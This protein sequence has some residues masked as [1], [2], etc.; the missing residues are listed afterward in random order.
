MQAVLD[1]PMFGTRWR[2]NA[3]RA[4]ALLRCRGGKKVPPPL[5]RMRAEDLLAAV[6]P[7][8][9]P[10]PRTSPASARSPTIRWCSRRSTTACTRRWTSTASRRLLERDRA[11]RA[12]GSSP[13][14][15]GAVAAA[16]EI[17]NARPYAFLDDAPL[18][19]RRTQAVAAAPLARSR[20]RGG[21][22]RAR[23]RGDR[24]RCARRPGPRRRRR[25][26]ARRA[27]LA[28]L[29]DRGG[30]RDLGMES[31]CST[32][33]SRRAARRGSPSA[34]AS[35]GG[36][37]AAAE[38]SRPSIRIGALEPEIPAPAESP[39]AQLAYARRPLVELVA[40]R[41]E[42]VG[43]VTAA[44]LAAR[45]RHHPWRRSRRRSPRS[46]AR[47]SC[48][49]AASRH[50]RDRPA[51]GTPRS[52]ASGAC[53]RASTATRSARCAP[54]SS[55]S[56][57]PTSCASCSTGSVSRATAAGG[58]TSRW[59]RIVA[60]LEGF[61]IPAAAWER[62]MLPARVHDYDPTGSTPFASPGGRS[63]PA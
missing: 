15:A 16:H 19:E 22:G 1:A 31:R 50:L 29:P 36:G 37:R 55:P 2:W 39:R 44:T 61:E 63:G 3:S 21:L 24:A 13:A 47:A 9:S 20:D 8:S 7:S 60:Q 17:L 49:A 43:P 33:W 4:L 45:S 62:D 35:L 32:S 59:R 53:S 10:A 51:T 40:R 57:P 27:A 28:R 54:R 52:G 34:D 41:L 56:Q 25:R 18:E 42:G 46:R 23:P 48:C 14:T 26:A 6:F 12:Y 11:R 58:R 30:G 5:Q 38:C